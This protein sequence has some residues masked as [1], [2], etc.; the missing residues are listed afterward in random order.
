MRHLAPESGFRSLMNFR[1]LMV[2]WGLLA[3]VLAAGIGA[4]LTSSDALA[5]QS[6]TREEIRSQL[7]L[8]YNQPNPFNPSTTINYTLLQPAD[9]QVHVYDLKG[10]HLVCLV[11]E[12]QQEGDNFAIWKTQTAPSGTYIFSL[13]ADGVRVFRKM[14]LVR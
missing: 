4:L 13:E 6:V 8:V 9:V 12:Y 2:A 3:V 14:M 7:R 1:L 5:D 11:D 10:R